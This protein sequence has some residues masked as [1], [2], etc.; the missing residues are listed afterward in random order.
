MGIHGGDIYKNQVKLDF[1]TNVNPLGIPGTVKK[2]MHDAVEICGNYP[3]IE[4]ERLKNAVSR[5]LGVSKKWLLFGNGASELFLA[6]VHAVRPKKIVIPV[7][8]FFGYEYAAQAAGSEIVYYKMTQENDFRIQEDFFELLTEDVD[9][10]FLAN[11]NNPTG[12]LQDQK[13]LEHL[14]RHCQNQGIYVVFDEC[15]IEFSGARFSMF[16]KL[17]QYDHLVLIRA[18]TKIFSIPGVR[19]GYLICSN[20][21]LLAKT[22]RQLP[23]WNLSCIAQEAGCACAAQTAFISETEQYVCKERQFLEKELKK[24]GFMIFP[25]MANFILF[26]IKEA[27]GEKTLYESLLEKEILIRDCRNF[28][29]LGP[30]YYRIAVKSRREN[31][32][33]LEG[34]NESIRVSIT[35]RNRKTQL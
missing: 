12:K 14:F 29:G 15:F 23:E 4:A 32:C 35:G 28:R 17:Q 18:F 8:S 1:S 27:E 6:I 20:H 30:G 11:P 2:A 9:M 26:Y 25:S 22:A 10:L 5:M 19:L 21:Q 31:E 3:D 33:L 7:P 34:L 13:E 24:R 16:S